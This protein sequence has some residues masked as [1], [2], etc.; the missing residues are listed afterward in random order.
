MR[1]AA[2]A[3]RP[4]RNVSVI[5]TRPLRDRRDGRIG[6]YAI[7]TWPSEV[8]ERAGYRTLRGLVKVTLENRDT[9]LAQHFTL[10]DFLTK[11]QAQVWPKCV[12][13]DTRLVDKLERVLEE[14][15]RAGY[16]TPG[17]TVLSGFRTPSYNAT[18]GDTRGR[19]TVLRHL[20]GDAADGFLD[21]DGDGRMDDL[22][23]NGRVTI[24]DARVILR[25][26]ERVERRHPRLVGG[27]GVCP[28][29]TA[30]GPFIHVDTRG[31]PARW[32]G[33]AQ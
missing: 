7:G 23:G 26:V 28:D 11:G 33:E 2:P 6:G 3:G 5:T 18:G 1:C 10:R 14:L 16:E 32:T 17:V 22:D 19:A 29:G 9:P 8:E 25:A 13:V 4:L 12:L 31:Y 24:A 15:R 27:A 20:C 21:N 30:H